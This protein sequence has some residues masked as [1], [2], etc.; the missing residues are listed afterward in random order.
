[1]ALFCKHEWEVLSDVMIP[2]A[3][4]QVGKAGV[5]SIKNTAPGFFRKVHHVVLACKKCGEIRE[6]RAANL[7][8]D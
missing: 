8:D 7:T 1:M 3:F 6:S 4:E 5:K 2:S